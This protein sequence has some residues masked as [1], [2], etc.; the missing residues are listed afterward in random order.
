MKQVITSLIVLA[1]AITPNLANANQAENQKKIAVVKKVVSNLDNRTNTILTNA[2]PELKKVAQQAEKI[3][4]RY[5]T[6]TC[7]AWDIV[8]GQDYDSQKLV[9]QSA[10]YSVLKNGNARVTFRTFH[11]SPEANTVIFK[12]QKSGKRQLITDIYDN[13]TSFISETKACLKRDHGITL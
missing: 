7:A 9:T 2:A 1:I 4:S 10:K 8:G 6:V 13:N 5:D 3:A 12:F 11:D